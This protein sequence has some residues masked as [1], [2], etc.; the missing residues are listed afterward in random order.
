[1]PKAM[2][3]AKCTMLKAMNTL[4]WSMIK[5]PHPPN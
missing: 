1:M 2:N 3:K 5:G 4:K